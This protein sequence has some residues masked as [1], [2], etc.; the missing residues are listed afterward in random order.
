VGL[1]E[2]V[3]SAMESPE[4][5]LLDEPLFEPT[6]AIPK[7]ARD[8]RNIRHIMLV[9]T[10]NEPDLVGL[11]RQ[12]FPS[13]GPDDPVTLRMTEDVWAKGQLVGAIVGR[14]EADVL[15]FVSERGDQ[16]ARDFARAAVL[17]LARRLRNDG[18]ASGMTAALEERFGWSIAPPTGYDFFTTNEA[19]RFVFFRR[20]RPDRSV[21][22]YWE[23][24][25]PDA[26]TEELAIAWREELARRYYDGDTV[27]R[28]RPLDVQ[29]VDFLGRDAIRISGW[30]GNRE[31][32]GGGTFRSY[33]FYE[34]TQDR[35]YMIDTSLF[36]PGF[37]KISL[38]RN[39]DAIAHTFS[40]AAEGE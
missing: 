16:A 30:W 28:R 32:V 21:F 22:V 17:R 7:S 24:G 23:E 35:T 10:W 38:M 1:I 9:G 19:E 26:I 12:A 29:R 40:S 2:P 18:D 8:S 5:W 6:L 37:D 36:A 13:L 33:C 11:V 31:L 39:L 4:G 20:V 15:A 3:V 27:E 14:T 25:Q 34:P